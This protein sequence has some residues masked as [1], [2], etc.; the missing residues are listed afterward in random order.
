[1]RGYNLFRRRSSKWGVDDRLDIFPSLASVGWIWTRIWHVV[2]FYRRWFICCPY[3]ALLHSWNLCFLSQSLR[4]RRLKV[5]W[6][7]QSREIDD[8]AAIVTNHVIIIVQWPC[9]ANNC[10]H[11]KEML[12]ASL[13]MMYAHY[14]RTHASILCNWILVARSHL[15]FLESERASS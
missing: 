6:P 4:H 5:R 13:V 15:P 1:M 3:S 2:F 12:R 14:R 7:A 8:L 11:S 10:W 9:F